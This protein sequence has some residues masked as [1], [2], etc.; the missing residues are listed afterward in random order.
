MPHPHASPHPPPMTSSCPDFQRDEFGPPGTSVQAGGPAEGV[1]PRGRRG[2][3]TGHCDSALRKWLK[4][5]SALGTPPTPETTS[6][7][8]GQ[9]QGNGAGLAAHPHPLLPPLWPETT[10]P[11]APTPWWF[12]QSRPRRSN[13]VT[14]GL[15]PRIIPGSSPLLLCSQAPMPTSLLSQG[16]AGTTPALQTRQLHPKEKV[17]GP[18]QSYRIGQ[19]LCQSVLI[20]G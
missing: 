19:L 8:S 13:M 12:Q 10:E 2:G 4:Q 20:D 3:V 7:F 17:R 16:P 18:G 14:S 11:Q 1:R 9:K 5:A 6:H 15:H